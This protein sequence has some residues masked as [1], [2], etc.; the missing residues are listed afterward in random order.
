MK[1]KNNGREQLHFCNS[2]LLVR[3]KFYLRITF[4]QS[5]IQGYSALYY[6]IYCKCSLGKKN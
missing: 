4:C 5:G 3:R 6:Q 1:L 2:D